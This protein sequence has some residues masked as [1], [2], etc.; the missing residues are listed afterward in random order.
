MDSVASIRIPLST[1]D[2]FQE[3]RSAPGFRRRM[4]VAEMRTPRSWLDGAWLI[5]QC[6]LVLA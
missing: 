1:P 4:G 5:S 3:D 6:A 2:G